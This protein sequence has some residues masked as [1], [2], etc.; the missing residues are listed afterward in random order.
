MKSSGQRIFEWLKNMQ[1]VIYIL[2]NH[3]IVK[4]EHS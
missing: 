3:A 1:I 2:C 4:L